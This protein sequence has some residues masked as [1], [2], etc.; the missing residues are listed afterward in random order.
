M[1]PFSKAWRDEYADRPIHSDPARFIAGMPQPIKPPAHLRR[2]VGR[3]LRPKEC[4]HRAALYM[5][6][7]IDEPGIRL[8]YGTFDS[9]ALNIRSEHSWVELPGNLAFDGTRQEFYRTDEYRVVIRAETIQEYTGREIAT[10]ISL[11]KHT[12]P[13]DV[14]DYAA[15]QKSIHVLALADP[16]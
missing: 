13:W 7:H 9:L 12:G 4:H 8:V 2:G 3:V 14:S 16:S 1:K 15:A 5:L 11:T 10:L 6:N